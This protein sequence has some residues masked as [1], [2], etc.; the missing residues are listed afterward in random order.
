M[1]PPTPFPPSQAPST[2]H[3]GPTPPQ[4]GVSGGEGPVQQGDHCCRQ[5]IQE[6]GGALHV[7][8]V[9]LRQRF[10]DSAGPIVDGILASGDKVIKCALSMESLAR[11]Q[12]ETMAT[13][14]QVYLR[15]K[16]QLDRLLAALT[17]QQK[18]R[19]LRCRPC[20][21]EFSTVSLSRLKD[22]TDERLTV[23]LE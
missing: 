15:K 6:F 22:A 8:A 16:R 5:A 23:F 18:A 14:K 3:A 7:A 19:L 11:E 10:G 2:R 1:S 21:I 20:R 13:E 17:K 9:S 4:G 12:L